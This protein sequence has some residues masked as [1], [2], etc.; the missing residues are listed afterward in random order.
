MHSS[1]R[2]RLF[3]YKWIDSNIKNL[4]FNME[5]LVKGNVYYFLPMVKGL[6]SNS[7]I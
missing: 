1:I 2:I 3:P 6:K 7:V 4:V 5:K